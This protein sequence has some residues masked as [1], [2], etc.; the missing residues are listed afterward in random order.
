MCGADVDQQNLG[1]HVV[2][3]NITLKNMDLKN[4]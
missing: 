4:I 2:I 1:A 3:Y